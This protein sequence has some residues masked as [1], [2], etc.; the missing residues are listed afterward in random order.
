VLDLHS[1][2]VIPGLVGMH[3]HV[4]YP[5]G[6]EFSARWRLAFLACISPGV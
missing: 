6:N 4:F 3:D 2:S 5:V 1:Y